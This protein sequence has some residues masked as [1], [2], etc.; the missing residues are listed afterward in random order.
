ME[1]I[2][3]PAMEDH[4]LDLI[5]GEGPS[6]RSIRIDLAP[7]TLVAA[8]TRAGLLATPL[9]D[10]FGIPLRLEFYTPEEL[11]HGAGPGRPQDGRGPDARGRRRD[12]RRARAARPASPAACCAGCATSPAPRAPRCIDRAAAARA[13]ARLEVDEAGLDSL[14]RR[15]LRALIENYGGGPAGVETLAYAIAEARDAVE[16]VIEPFLHAAGLHP[17]HAARAGGLRQGLSAHRPEAARRAQGP[18]GPVR[19]RVMA[20]RETSPSAGWFEGREHLLPVRVYYEDTDF[21]GVVYH[22]NYARYFERGRSD[23]LRLAGISHTDLLAHDEPTAFVVTRLAIDF[24]AAAR[25]DD[26]LLVRTT[27]DAVRGPRLFIS[28]R[29]VR[30]ETV[31]CEAEVQAACISLDG[32]ARRPPRGM[33]ETLDSLVQPRCAIVSPPS[34]A[35]RS[36]QIWSL[37]RNG[38]A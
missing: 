11:H 35:N 21:T 2:L 34:P 10:R 7:F 1:E 33:V 32:R 15:Y 22:A 6:A 8:T 23:F 36:E 17:A 14:D 3:Y 12:R 5:I 9:R 20:A 19:G 13:L 29:I 38:C 31:I 4:V 30:G 24:R 37:R 18:A 25:I 28:Q 27:Y 26:A 16:D